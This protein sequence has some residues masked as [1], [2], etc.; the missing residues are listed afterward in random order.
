LSERLRDALGDL[1]AVA[2]GLVAFFVL[3]GWT[4]LIPTNIAWLSFADRGMHTLGWW[5]F[6]KADWSMPPGRSPL[7]GVELSNSIGLVDGLPLFALPF[8][9]IRGWLPQ[10]FQ[11]WGD[12][13]LLSF[14]LQSLFAYGIAR[15]LGTARLVALA[16]AGFALIT[17]AFLFRI[18]M[19][20]ALSGHWTIL[21]ALFLYV[22]R[23]PPPRWMWPLLTAVVSAIHAYL[24]AMVFAIW[25]AALI[26]RVWTKRLSWRSGALELVL[27]LAATL[28]VLW[29]A[30]FFTSGSTGT[31]GYGDYKLNLLWPFLSYRDWSTL[32]PDLPHTKYDY[33]GLSFL[34]IGI[35][36]L[37]AVT[38]FSGAILGVR[39]VLTRRWLPLAVVVILLMVFAVSQKPALLD[40]PLF[41]IE[42]PQ[43]LVDLLSTF[44][45]T[46]RFV[47]PL[48]YIVT[49][50]TIVLVGRRFS[51]RVAVLVVVIALAG[52][53]ADSWRG[54]VIFRHS[55]PSP[56][57]TW[58]TELTSPFWD[59][60][61]AAGYDRVRAYPIVQGPAGD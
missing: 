51:T 45:S 2:L 22:R 28:F 6:E 47:W 7:L 1:A 39:S 61:A 48:L 46:G 38:V 35:L 10:P 18:P 44:R 23:E 9:L 60:A 29:I 34:G 3:V 36:A 26:E 50:G 33:E 42:L 24:L 57:S 30:G 56:S 11:Y 4:T 17:P 14:A 58:T 52:Q 53:V 55:L 54:L 21:A 41:A 40:I 43:K 12:W 13:I 49:I 59:R 8:K 5:F 31:Y 27:G 20:M 19:H 16:A 25:G 32:L 15:Q 37:L